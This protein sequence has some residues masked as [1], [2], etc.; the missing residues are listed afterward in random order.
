MPRLLSSFLWLSKCLSE[1]GMHRYKSHFSTLTI[2][3]IPL[4]QRSYAEPSHS[5]STRSG[6]HFWNKLPEGIV[7]ATSVEQAA[8]N[9][10]LH[11]GTSC[12]R[13]LWPL[14]TWRHS[15]FDWTH[16]GSPSSQKF[17][18]NP[19]PNTP[20]HTCS[21]LSYPTLCHWCNYSWSSIVVFTAH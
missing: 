5:K 20:S 6:S 14:H 11:F 18:S 21:T 12:Q 10:L 2:G 13:I 8:R 19:S 1:R 9:K 16:N 15:N 4:V 7:T 17:P 3:I